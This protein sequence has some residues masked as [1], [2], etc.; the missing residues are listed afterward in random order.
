MGEI[1]NCNCEV[2]SFIFSDGVL[3][4]GKNSKSIEEIVNDFMVNSRG[5]DR[6]IL[7]FNRKGI[8]YF[9]ALTRSEL[10]KNFDKIMYF[11]GNSR[12]C[13]FGFRFLKKNEEFLMSLDDALDST[14]NKYEMP[15]EDFA[16]IALKCKEL[17]ENVNLGN[18][19]EYIISG[20]KKDIIDRFRTKKHDVYVFVKINSELCK[21]K[22]ASE[23]KA[24]FAG[25]KNRPLFDDY[26]LTSGYKKSNGSVKYDASLNI[27]MK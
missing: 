24:S 10:K 14:G 16:K 9:K 18:I 26:G 7:S 13:E 25:Q 17:D 23:C 21:V 3:K 11:N 1:R 2:G 4:S 12:G 22:K 20:N 15:E 5:E 8:I 27:R 6:Y 19:A